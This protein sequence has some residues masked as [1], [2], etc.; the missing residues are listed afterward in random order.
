MVIDQDS[1][2]YE[3]AVAE[4]YVDSAND[5][6]LQPATQTCGSLNVIILSNYPHLY[7]YIK[8]TFHKMHFKKKKI[9]IFKLLLSLLLFL[10]NFQ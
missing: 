7:F 3:E 10:F 1:R 4:D 6:C 8:R 2:V 9:S 5:R